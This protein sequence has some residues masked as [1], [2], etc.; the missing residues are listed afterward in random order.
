MRIM[1]HRGARALAFLML[2]QTVASA[3][4]T[5]SRAEGR[6][7]PPRCCFT[8]RA[9]AGTCVVEPATDETCGQILD[10]LNNPLSQGKT[11]CNATAIRGGW[12]SVPCRK[13][14]D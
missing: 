4:T 11:Y 1:T 13:G 10:Y 2:I 9:Y 8:N 6:D 12:Q 5:A 7:E 14:S 3:S